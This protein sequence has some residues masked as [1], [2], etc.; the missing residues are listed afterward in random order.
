MNIDA[1]TLHEDTPPQQSLL[2]Q[3]RLSTTHYTTTCI[4][5]DIVQPLTPSVSQQLP[6]QHRDAPTISTPFAS[7]LPANPSL[8]PP[9]VHDIIPTTIRTTT[10]SATHVVDIPPT[11]TPIVD[12]VHA[13]TQ[14]DPEP[15]YLYC[16]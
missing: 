7:L 3:R 2:P 14:T 6:E 8:I 12:I 4:A 13:A 1:Q 10:V 9:D 5:Q 16:Q 15:F 11:T